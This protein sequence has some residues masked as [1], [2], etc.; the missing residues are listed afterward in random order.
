MD[1]GGNIAAARAHFG[2]P[3]GGW[4][5][6]STGINPDAYPFDES[7]LA[8][9]VWSAL[10]QFDRIA[11]LIE[12]ARVAYCVPQA[13]SIVAAPGTQAL[14][15][16]LPRVLMH[17]R[18]GLPAAQVAIVGPTYSEHAITWARSGAEVRE[19]SSLRAVSSADDIVVAV[20]PNNP[21][22]RL[23]AVED[24]VRVQRVLGARGGALIL[25][26]AFADV[27]PGLSHI[28]RT[29]DGGIIVLKSFGK[30]YGLAGVRLGFA[31][32]DGDV[33]ARLSV[34]LG[35]WAVS[36]PAIEIG[37]EALADRAWAQ[38]ARGE[39]SARAARLSTLLVGAG[40][41]LIG[42]GGLFVLVAHPDARTRHDAL[43][44]LGI[45]TRRFERY[46]TWLRFGLPRELDLP[47][48][49]AALDTL[50]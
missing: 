27:V 7:R 41:R 13:A 42:S 46:P 43:C 47:R 31:M 6:L 4:L 30:F 25:D 39:V 24:V 10:P 33:A 3:Q 23:F 37:I 11:T 49:A 29:G 17:A 28:D 16:V 5:D 40:F 21:D 1:H 26:E 18:T 50:G 20:H 19:I 45:L 35:P 34:E 9:P 12:A 14:I 15:Q 36:G 32:A 48:V 38:R 8:Q 22:G 2:E 44:R